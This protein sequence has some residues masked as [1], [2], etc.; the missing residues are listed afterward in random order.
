M[1]P[2]DQS[3]PAMNFRNFHLEGWL[4][5]RRFSLVKTL[6]RGFVGFL[7]LYGPGSVQATE[8]TMVTATAT[9]SVLVGPVSLIPAGNT[10][11]N[12]AKDGMSLNVSDRIV[13]GTQ[14]M[15]LVTF[16]DGSTLTVQPDSDVEVKKAEV[17]DEGSRIS[18]WIHL[19]TVWARV[20]SFV[21]PDSSFSLE[22]NT[23]T[24]TVH[25]GLIGG[26]QNPDTSFICWTLAGDL[27][28]EDRMGQ[29]LVTLK[30]G[31]KTK[32]QD[33]QDSGRHAFAVHHS[34]LK[35]TASPNLL[36][37]VLMP[38]NVRVSGF[39]APGLEV[40]Q[41]FGSHTG[42]EG[43][44]TRTVEVPAG[45]PGPFTLIVEGKAET[46]FTVM[47]EGFFKGTEVY[48]QNFAG[49]ITKGERLSTRITQELESTP[50]SNPKTA[51]VLNGQAEE[52]RSLQESLPG[53]IL[54]SPRESKQLTELA[55]GA[56]WSLP[57]TRH[58]NRLE[59]D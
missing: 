31:E 59:A 34:T 12:A 19:G 43:Y 47:V 21:D 32:V 53:I 26:Q 22:S 37:L 10:E 18:I 55:E 46:T 35:V 42:I 4:I 45:V 24:A 50:V 14:G 3:N 13:T 57:H 49:R 36:P 58:S 5:F 54:V 39:V 38:D 15:A 28:V 33:G 6:F 30:S 41:V 7:V 23:A 51:K 20:V 56:I 48:R 2:L 8:P 9:L 11:S 40:N 52:L 29:S 25:D 1:I 16:L 27:L 17:S 44:G